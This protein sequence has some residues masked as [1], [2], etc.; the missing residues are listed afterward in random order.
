MK[1]NK[2]ILYA[3]YALVSVIAIMCLTFLVV[4][5]LLVARAMFEQSAYQITAYP[6]TSDYAYAIIFD[7]LILVFECS[8][9]LR[10]GM[11]CARRMDEISMIVKRGE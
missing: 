6:I 5:P 4:F 11:L 8:M 9:V 2:L 1:M 10:I 3:D 7:I